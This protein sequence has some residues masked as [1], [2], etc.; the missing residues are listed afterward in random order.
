MLLGNGRTGSAADPTALHLVIA[1]AKP[2]PCISF[3][4]C[5][6]RRVH[7]RRQRRNSK[8]WTHIRS[9]L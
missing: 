5:D 4:G 6:Y 7:S 8:R 2:P 1:S 9:F 3:A